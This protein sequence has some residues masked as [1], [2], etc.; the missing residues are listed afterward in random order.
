MRRIYVAMEN[1]MVVLEP[2]GDDGWTPR[3]GLVESTPTCVAVDPHTPRRVYAGTHDHGLYRSD[4]AGESW[5]A[6][7]G[8]ISSPRIFSVAVSPQETT[9]AGGVVWCGTEPSGL[10]RSED[11]GSSW[12]EKPALLDLPSRP[13][14]SY[15]PRPWTHH[16]R[17]IEPD[18]HDARRLYVAIELGGVMRSTD[19][20]D[21]FEDRRRIGQHDGHQLA[22]HPDA[23]DRVYEAAG[24]G[25]AESSDAGESWRSPVSG[26]ADLT[27]LWSVAVDRGDPDTIVVTTANNARAAHVTEQAETYIFRR[28][29]G[30][31]WMRVSEG[32]PDAEGL[33]IGVLASDPEDAGVFWLANNHGVFVSRDAGVS[34]SALPVDWS[35]YARQH[36]QGIA[37]EPAG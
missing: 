6:A 35:D 28:A 22:T 19:G 10:W 8:R 21:S 3:T 30:T 20:G 15:P 2:A 17:W 29:A 27:Y 34:W 23:P 26:L 24:G 36:A 12:V 1:G 33:G 4:D 18:R 11:G 9:E 31:E 5:R 14:W 37:V 25:Y 16:V 7:H 32:L 13:T